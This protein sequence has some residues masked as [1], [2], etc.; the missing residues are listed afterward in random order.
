LDIVFPT[1]IMSEDGKEGW[2]IK[3]SAKIGKYEVKKE[4]RGTEMVNKG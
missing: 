4:K 3:A 1:E 2:K